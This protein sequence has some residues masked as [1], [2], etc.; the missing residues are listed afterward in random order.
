MT[1][2]NF[3][4]RFAPVFALKAAAG[5]ISPEAKPLRPQER[6]RNWDVL[7]KALP[8]ILSKCSG[9]DFYPDNAGY[10][11]PLRLWDFLNGREIVVSSNKRGGYD[12]C[13]KAENGMWT[14][15]QLPLDL[16]FLKL[17]ALDYTPEE[18]RAFQ[19]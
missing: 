9:I 2:S 7:M 14:E 4:A 10:P 15:T 8:S 1:Q 16:I 17:L 5:S 19:A 11:S 12:L 18:L 13:I 6:Q 3:E